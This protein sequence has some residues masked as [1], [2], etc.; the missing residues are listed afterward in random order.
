M[1]TL[2]EHTLVMRGFSKAYA[3]TGWRLGWCAGPTEVIE[4]MTMLQ[5]YTFVCAPS[6]AQAAGL[7]ALG[8]DVSQHV[9]AYRHKRDMVVDALGETFG[10]IR[11]NGAFYAFVPAPAGQTATEFVTE[12]IGRN[13][14]IIPGNVFSAADTHFRISY[15]ISDEKLARGLDILTAMV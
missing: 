8:T 6:M 7:T 10:L 15:A 14:L 2:Y 13:V 12:A 1:A 11:P 5:Q 9:A 3:M 4:A